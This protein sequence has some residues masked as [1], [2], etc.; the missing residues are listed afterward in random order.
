MFIWINTTAPN[1]R[2]PASELKWLIELLS[3]ALAFVSADS[4]VARKA[5]TGT[6]AAIRSCKQNKQ[7]KK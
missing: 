2:P 4:E 7:T 3:P 5:A 6:L 1:L